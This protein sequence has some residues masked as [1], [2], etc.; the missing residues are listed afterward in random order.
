MIL[1]LALVTGVSA[2]FADSECGKGYRD[3]TPTERATITANLEAA[4]KACPEPPAGWVIQG[5]EKV[6]VPMSTCK[7]YDAEPWGYSFTR[8]CQRLTGHEAEDS[9]MQVAADVSKT[10]LEAKQPRLDAIMARMQELGQQSGEAAQKGDW[11]K[12][13][14]LSK[15]IDKVGQ[16]YTKLLDDSA[17]TEA[18]NAAVEAARDASFNIGVNFNTARMWH[19]P[20]A[21]VLD[22]PGA[23]A[24]YRWGEKDQG[25]AL[26]LVGAWKPVDSGE[27]EGLDA[28]AMRSGGK[29]ES[30]QNV[31]IQVTGDET[32]VES[33][34]RAIDLKAMTALL[35]K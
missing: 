16:E 8:Y 15:E 25:V 17:S 23:A 10:S 13:D 32:R 1:G 30:A 26:I 2:A 31:V 27:G 34:A 20:A 29:S 4:K 18:L 21:V 22:I 7:D 9:L 14:A 35:G 19:D 11:D 6:S 5:D 33:V 28:C 12:V 24:A 3:T